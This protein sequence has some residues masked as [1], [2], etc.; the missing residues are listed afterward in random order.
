M[1]WASRECRSTGNHG[2][3]Q[4][5]RTTF[6]G[7]NLLKVWFFRID[8]GSTN[9]VFYII[10]SF[11]TLL[12]KKYFGNDRYSLAVLRTRSRPLMAV[13][14]FCLFINQRSRPKRGDFGATSHCFLV[15]LHKIRFCF[16]LSVESCVQLVRDKF[17]RILW[18]GCQST[19][20]ASSLGS[21]RSLPA[22]CLTK[23]RLFFSMQIQIQ[24]SKT[25]TGFRIQE[26]NWLWIRIHSPDIIILCPPTE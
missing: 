10:N 11:P 4:M 12:T 13:D 25:F 6:T 22:A 14:Y 23:Q 7:K 5:F 1:R 15:Q 26:E 16:N 17:L 2:P 24:L 8:L 3:Q 19:F 18:S 9:S 20:F 21:R